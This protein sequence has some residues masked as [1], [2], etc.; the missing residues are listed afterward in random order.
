MLVPSIFRENLFDDFFD[1]PAMRPVRREG[2]AAQELMKTNVR[3]TEGGFE[4]SIA[5]PGAKKEDIKVELSDGYL[6]V[7]A[8]T[9]YENNENGEDGKYLR[10]ERYYGSA[11]RSFYVGDEITEEDI[12]AKYENGVLTLNIPKKEAKPQLPEK[13]LIAIEG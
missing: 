3:E 10:R 11:S 13:K 2:K 8:E 7:A 6:S 5:T 1:M 4:I 12:K 9:K